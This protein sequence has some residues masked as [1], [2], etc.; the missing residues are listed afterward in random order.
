[1]EH[2]NRVFLLEPGHYFLE[3]VVAVYLNEA[4][5]ELVKDC[6]GLWRREF[7]AEI[8]NDVV[9]REFPNFE[10][11]EHPQYASQA[12]LVT[13]VT[14]LVVDLVFILEHLGDVH[15]QSV[16]EVLPEAR[17]GPK[18]LLL[19]QVCQFIVHLP[20]DLGSKRLPASPGGPVSPRWSA[21]RRLLRSYLLQREDGLSP[22][23]CSRTWKSLVCA[24]SYI[25]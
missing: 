24:F 13:W 3:E 16:D 1:M 20:S 9:E 11:L 15:V 23:Q 7:V 5:N 8:W 18:L 21:N 17:A 22:S 14:L 25:V 4:V 12:W 2:K 10:V 6:S 19:Y